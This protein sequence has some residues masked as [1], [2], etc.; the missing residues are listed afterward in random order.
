MKKIHAWGLKNID[1]LNGIFMAIQWGY[2]M[3]VF[4]LESDSALKEEWMA[5]ICVLTGAG[6]LSVIILP[7]GVLQQ[8]LFGKHSK[9]IR[10]SLIIL[11]FYTEIFFIFH[12][13]YITIFSKTDP[14]LCFA[15]T[16]VIFIYSCM[17]KILCKINRDKKN[18]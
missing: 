7:F 15:N 5:N 9:K 6:Y 10:H 12:F 2:L 13:I 8:K 1:F 17:E 11:L 18:E 4:A 14:M 16:G 3:V